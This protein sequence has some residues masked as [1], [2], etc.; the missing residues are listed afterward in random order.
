MGHRQNVGAL[1]KYFNSL[2]TSETFSWLRDKTASFIEKLGGT[3]ARDFA[4][5]LEGTTKTLSSR[6]CCSTNSGCAI[7]VP[8]TDT[9]FPP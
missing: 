6:P 7:S 1:A 8:W 5:K 3:Q 9:T 4:F 2:Q